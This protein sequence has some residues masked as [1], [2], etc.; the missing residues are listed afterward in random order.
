MLETP[1]YCMRICNESYKHTDILY[2]RA[3]ELTKG[4]HALRALCSHR[5]RG[6]K[7][8]P[9]TQDLK[10]DTPDLSRKGSHTHSEDEPAHFHPLPQP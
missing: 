4:A 6:T 5:A 1:N 8:S 3:L 2:V 10:G 7:A 9:G